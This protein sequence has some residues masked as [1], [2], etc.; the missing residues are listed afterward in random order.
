MEKKPIALTCLWQ[1]PIRWTVWSFQASPQG[2]WKDS[3]SEKAWPRAAV[4][5]NQRRL[6]RKMWLKT[7]RQ[8]PV[9]EDSSTSN[10]Q[11]PASYNWHWR[12]IHN[13]STAL[14]H[15]W[16]LWPCGNFLATAESWKLDYNSP[17]SVSRKLRTLNL[18]SLQIEQNVKVFRNL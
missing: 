11:T 18:G 12:K 3:L 17:D 6:T 4:N 8:W 5:D 2:S 16:I 9:H 1:F 15:C 13:M 7:S 14:L 10:G